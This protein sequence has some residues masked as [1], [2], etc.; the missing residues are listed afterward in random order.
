MPSDRTKEQ[1]FLAARPSSA[2]RARADRQR[3]GLS[4]MLISTLEGSGLG[5]SPDELWASFAPFVLPVGAGIDA[6]WRRELPRRRRALLRKV[7]R[8][9]LRG[10]RARDVD[11]IRHEYDRTWSRLDVDGYLPGRPLA[12]GVPWQWRLRRA[13]APEVGGS[14]FRLLL[15]GR[16]LE[17]LAPG[18]VLEVGSGNGIN[19]LS[20]AGAYP[21][22]RLAGIELTEAGHRAALATR[23][24]PALPEAIPAVSHRPPCR[25][26]RPSDG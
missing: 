10:G 19:L 18:S 20:L 1:Y 21:Q 4:V 3:V 2:R 16:M 6:F 15:I 22:V 17:K 11:A 25:T 14:R 24:R 23:E 12:E 26:Q 7:A 5:L 13:L 8:G 9:L